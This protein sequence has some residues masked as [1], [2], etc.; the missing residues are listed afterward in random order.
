V[1]FEEMLWTTER[2]IVQKL[3][4]L[5]IQPLRIVFPWIFYC[6]IGYVEVEQFFLILDRVI[7]AQSL[8]ILPLYCISVMFKEKTAILEAKSQGEIQ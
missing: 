8:E 7:G 3:E 5:K 6:F 1:L 4:E 2:K